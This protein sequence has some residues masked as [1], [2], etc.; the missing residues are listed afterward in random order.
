MVPVSLV[1]WGQGV[2]TLQGPILLLHRNK[3]RVGRIQGNTANLFS[4]SV[5]KIDQH[6]I[7]KQASSLLSHTKMHLVLYKASTLNNRN[8]AVKENGNVGVQR[9][10]MKP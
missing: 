6:Y 2:P 3:S 7:Y 9:M 1:I 5:L 4:L 10:T 8:D